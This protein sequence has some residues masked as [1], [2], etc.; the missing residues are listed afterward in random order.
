MGMFDQLTC[1][2]PL[3]VD[4]A[5]ARCYQTKDLECRMDNYEIREDGTLWHE[6]Y[7]AG[8]EESPDASLGFWIHRDNKRWEQIK[9]TGEV[10]FYGMLRET[11][12][13]GWIEWS[14]YFADGMLKELHLVSHEL[15]ESV[16]ARPTD[17]EIGTACGSADKSVL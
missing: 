15:P 3:T 12:P 9:F 10:R 17:L 6:D 1:R 7:D 16:D 14:A 11:E 5:N 8:V 2:Y 4:G 13:Y